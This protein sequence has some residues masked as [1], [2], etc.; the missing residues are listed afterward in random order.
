M[1]TFKPLSPRELTDVRGTAVARPGVTLKEAKLRPVTQMGFA[2]DAISQ[3][4]R[5]VQTLTVNDLEDLAKRMA[6]VDVKNSQ[7]D[8]LTVEDLQGIH[9]LFDQQREAALVSIASRVGAG[10]MV[11]DAAA[12]VNV[13]CCCCTPC[14]CCAATST[15][16]FDA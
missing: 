14:C 15:H 6:G 12:D 5:Q 11:G 16:P 13:S 8:S 2:K 4:S 7:L 3:V 9:F 1:P 10:G